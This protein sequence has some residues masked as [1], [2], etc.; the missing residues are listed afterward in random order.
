MA[1]PFQVLIDIPYILKQ[2]MLVDSPQGTSQN[3]VRIGSI[4]LKEGIL[5]KLGRSTG[6][7]VSFYSH[8]KAVQM[9]KAATTRQGGIWQPVI[10]VAASIDLQEPQLIILYLFLRDKA[11]GQLLL[12]PA[13]GRQH[14]QI[15]EDVLLA[16]EVPY[17]FY[18]FQ[19]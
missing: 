19:I 13:S 10:A 7:Y 18:F 15:G 9:L 12:G 5:I 11:I 8:I 16:A 2:G 17:L 1:L 3:I 4:V 6:S 14:L